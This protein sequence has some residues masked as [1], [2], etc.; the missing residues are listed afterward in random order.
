MEDSTI[1]TDWSLGQNPETVIADICHHWRWCS[2]LKSVPFIAQR[3]RNFGL[4]W[5]ILAFMLRTCAFFGVLLYGGGV[6]KDQILNEICE[7]V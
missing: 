6:P 3:M 1:S 2:F 7:K 5:P 4:F